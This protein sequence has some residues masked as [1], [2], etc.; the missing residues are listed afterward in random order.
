MSIMYVYFLL[1]AVATLVMD[2]FYPIFRQSY[3]WWAVPVAILGFFIAFVLVQFITFWFMIVGTNTKAKPGRG[4][5]FFRFLL[6]HSLPTIINVVRVHIRASGLEKLSET[7]RKFFLVCNHQHDFDPAVLFYCFPD[8]KLSFVGKK[9]IEGNMKLIT[10]IMHR[11]RCLYIDRENDREAA[12]TIITAIKMLKE[13]SSSIALFPEGYC[14]DDD[15]ILPLRNGSLK[16]ALK[17]K[18]P[19]AVC[20]INNTKQIKKRMFKK[21]TT[22]DFRLIEV[23]EPEFYENMTTTELGDYIHEKMVTNLNEIREERTELGIK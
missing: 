13:G 17:S 5:W 2:N 8:A 21:T 11:L 9:E 16:V 12:K 18:A 19:V 15:E 22:V 20:V 23:L 10:K 3:S 1:S 14:S 7:N 6:K 4:E